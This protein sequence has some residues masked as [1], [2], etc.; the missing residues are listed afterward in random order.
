MTTTRWFHPIEHFARQTCSIPNAA[1]DRSWT[2]KSY[3]SEGI[4]FA[5]F[6]TYMD[7]HLRQHTIHMDKILV[8]IG[9]PPNEAK[10]LLRLIYSAL[11]DVESALIGSS[12]TGAQ[13]GLELAETIYSR[14]EEITSIIAG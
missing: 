6:R 9:Q 3:D 2:W 13:A 10:R 1:L 11:A 14:G 8:G 5:F 7:S 12:D 4:R